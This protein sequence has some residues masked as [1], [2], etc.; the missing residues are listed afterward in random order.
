MKNYRNPTSPLFNMKDHIIDEKCKRFSDDKEYPLKVNSCGWTKCGKSYF[1][2]CPAF[3]YAI[4][5]VISGSGS[6]QINDTICYPKGGDSYVIKKNVKQ[7]MYTEPANPWTKLWVIFSGEL[8]DS[9]FKIY[10]LND[11]LYYENLDLRKP[12]ERI[13]EI[14]NSELS[15]EE[16]NSECTVVIMELIQKLYL[17]KQKN[18][19]ANENKDTADKLKSL[20]DNTWKANVSLEDLASQVYC[21]R[22]HA[23]HIFKEK[24]GI[25][26]YKYLQD[27]RLKNAKLLLRNLE[28]NIGEIAQ[29]LRFCDSKYFSNWFKK[30]TGL[31]PREYRVSL[32]DNDWE[33]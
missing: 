18:I 2:S 14:C 1:I 13:I 17:H 30:T 12:I 28:L 4:E 33:E 23:I 9:L 27:V 25:T 26:P 7:D 6:V 21:S 11:Q 31:S 10:K 3:S 32:K 15:A 5:Y 19:A 20:I 8:A 24:F 22:N 29:L 16:R